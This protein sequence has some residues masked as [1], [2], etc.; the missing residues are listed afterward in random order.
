CAAVIA[1]AV[2]LAK[3]LGISVTAEGIETETQFEDVRSM[4]ID[5]AQG[6]LFGRPVPYDRFMCPSVVQHELG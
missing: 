6:Y 5:F 3:G 4:G 2:V 1:S